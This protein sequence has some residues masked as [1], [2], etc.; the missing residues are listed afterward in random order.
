MTRSGCIGSQQYLTW[1]QHKCL[2][3][4]S[5]KF[6][7]TRQSNHILHVGA[8]CQSRAEPAG[9]SLNWTAVACW[10]MPGGIVMY[11][12]CECPSGPIFKW[13]QRI[14]LTVILS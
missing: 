7:C 10:T 14:M 13:T 3:V 8:V 4:A 9:V 5:R 1:T 6:E 12:T 2:T 11:S